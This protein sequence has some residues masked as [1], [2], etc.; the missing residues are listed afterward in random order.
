M[1]F[2]AYTAGESD[3]SRLTDALAAGQGKNVWFAR[4]GRGSITE[5][6]ASAS[7]GVSLAWQRFGC[8]AGWHPARRLATGALRRVSKLRRAGCQP[9][10]NLPHKAMPS[11][12]FRIQT[13]R[14]TGRSVS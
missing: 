4:I 9:V 11:V 2:S 7:R 3:A 12:A 13:A 8:G 6:R 10:A 5:P 14:P 1:S